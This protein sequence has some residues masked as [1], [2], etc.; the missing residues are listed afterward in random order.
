MWVPTGRKVMVKLSRKTK[1]PGGLRE[2]MTISLPMVVSHGSETA[3]TF[4]DRLFLST[5][6]PVS[7]NASMIG[8]LSSFMMMTFFIGLIGYATALVAQYFGSGQ[9][10]R[11][12][13]VLS[14][15]AIL[16]ILAYPL[17]LLMRPLG[18][19]L[20]EL[21][22][23][24]Q[25]QLAPQKMYFDILIYG[26]VFVLL[27][28]SFSSFF[29]GIGRTRV[30]MLAAL[31]T[32]SVNIVVN[33]ILIFGR[34]GFPALGL[35]GAAYGTLTGSFCGLLVL[36]ARYQRKKNR[37][38]FK[39]FASLHFDREVMF[40]L[41][42]FGSPAGI[43]MF[44]NLLAFTL[45]M[46]LFH[47][48]GLVTATAVTIVFNWDMVSFVPL[49]GIQIGVVSLVGRYMGA[50]RPDIAV[51]TAQ[52]GLKMAWSYSS[53]ILVIF[54]ALPELLVSVF[55][56]QATDPLYLEAYPLAVEMLRLAALYVLADATIV[57]YSGTLRGAGDTFWTMCLSVF[58]HWALV[59]ILFVLLRTFALPPQQAWLAVILFF[60]IFS[61]V[62]YWRYR[63]GRW[64]QV[65][66]IS[67]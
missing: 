29:S 31:V 13:L 40:K 24:P 56:P 44:L 37:R 2:M 36:V 41:L 22:N 19:V 60:M 50:G 59:L 8:G 49:L 12:A 65:Q 20:F 47:S 33:Y 32:M 63:R 64:K 23:S 25:E 10:D 5:L 53:V 42:R 48:D 7:M 1:R 54:V 28:T 6:G 30:V 52:S 11:C 62:F 14:Q 17:I 4:T 21:M 58:M 26:A 67:S 61:A 43:E 35:K 3:M 57:V 9:R 51:R 45:M 55:Q 27:K 66:M 38:R 16:A 46:L 18:H 34:F 39:I 15:A